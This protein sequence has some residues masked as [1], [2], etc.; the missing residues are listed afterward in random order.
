MKNINS[1]QYNTFI[2]FI[3]R[4]GFLELTLTSILYNV[5]EDSYIAAIIGTILGIIPLFILEYLKNKCPKDNLI[6]LNKKL[7][8]SRLINIIILIGSL[9][10]NVATF[11]ILIHFANSLFLYKTSLW[12]ISLVL[13][14][15]I[16]YTSSKGMH[17]IAKVSQLLFYISV[18]LNILIMTGL[19]GEISLNNFNPIMRSKPDKLL[20]S[21]VLFTS[22]NTSK[23]FF[24]SIIPKNKI[25]NYNSKKNIIAYILTCINLIDITLSIICIFGIDLTLLYEYPAFQILKRVNILGV[26]DR[27]ETI[28]SVEAILS[29]FI[30][31]T[32][33]TYYIDSIIKKEIKKISKYSLPLICTFTYIF[34]NIL[35][36]TYQSGEAFI[37]NQMIYIF[38]IICIIIP[39]ITLFKFIKNPK[40]VKK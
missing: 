28:L 6:T 34:S 18:I 26:L 11:W 12:I 2:W 19:T 38:V 8:K 9:I 7:F 4:A 15:P 24:L 25:T 1:F 5:K 36:K 10:I 39:L 3:L 37:S 22:L 31:L 13:I 30:N 33:I 35:F 14:I 40:I 17:V 23:L 16:Y 20:L 27:L 32:I 21:S 29:L